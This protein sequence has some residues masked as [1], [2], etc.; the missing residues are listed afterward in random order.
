MNNP[1]QYDSNETTHGGH[2]AKEKQVA[3]IN[4]HD[5]RTGNNDNGKEK[6]AEYGGRILSHFRNRVILQPILHDP[7]L[8][9]S[10]WPIPT[11]SIL[12]PAYRW[13]RPSPWASPRRGR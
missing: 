9:V 2:D 6:T 12:A 1:N 10:P 8:L 11:G 5:H 4:Q 3:F 7:P 13:P